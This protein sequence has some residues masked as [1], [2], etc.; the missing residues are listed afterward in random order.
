[1]S[2]TFENDNDVT[3][4][5]LKKIISYARDNQYIFLAQSIWWI[6]SSSGLQQELIIHIDISAKCNSVRKPYAN[7]PDTLVALTTAL[8]TLRCSQPPLE[9]CKVRSDS[10]KAFSC[11]PQST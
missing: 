11:A 4:Y 9:L 5:A 3:V 2:I 7:L 6:S 1:M 10:V 8:S